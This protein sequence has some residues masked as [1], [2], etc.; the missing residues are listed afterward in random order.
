MQFTILSLGNVEFLSMVLNGV[1]MICGT[2]NFTQLVAVGFVLG[3]LFIG[4]QCIFRGGQQINLHHSF[5]CFLCYLCMFG[6]SCTVV[7]EDAYNGQA[8]TV[9]N[10]PLGVGAAGAAI[11]GIGYGVTRLIEQGYGAADRTSEQLGGVTAEALYREPWGDA[12]Q[13]PSEAH[14]VLLPIGTVGT[15]ETVTCAKGYDK[16]NSMFAKL[17]STAVKTAVNRMLKI[18]S[19]DGTTIATDYAEVTNAMDAVN[20]TMNGAQDLMQMIVLE[21]V[22]AEAAQKFY[23]TQ[24]D[25]A[26]A[27]AVNQAIMQRNTQWAAESTMFI[28]VARALMA[29]F[30]G[31]IYAITP[32]VAFLMAIGTFGVMLVGKYFLTIA[33]IQ[34]WLPI[35]SIVNLYTL[36]ACRQAITSA[37]LG[38]SAS[39]YALDVIWQDTQTWI[40]T[41]GMLLASTPM[42]A[43]FLVTG[44]T[45]A[46]TT[47]A[48][49]M[50]GQDHFNERIQTPDAV[51]PS[52]VM[53][54]ASTFSSD[55]TAGVRRTGAD[56]VMPTDNIGQT[57]SAATRSAWGTVN[58][59][60]QATTAAV[61]EALGNSQSA[62]QTNQFMRQVGDSMAASNNQ[63]FSTAIRKATQTAQK[64]GYSADQTHAAVAELGAA[65]QGRVTASLG[66]AESD[67][68][69]EAW[70]K[71]LSNPAKMI[72][73]ALGLE[74]KGSVSGS[75]SSGF[76]DQTGY[77]SQHSED[78]SRSLAADKS[79][80]MASS[81]ASEYS[82]AVSNMSSDQYAKLANENKGSSLGMQFAKMADARKAYETSESVA[83]SFG[84]QWSINRLPLSQMLENSASGRALAEFH[85][86]PDLPAGARSQ[87]VADANYFAPMMGG[88]MRQAQIAAAV[89]YMIQHPEHHAELGQK[90]L[91]S[92]LPMFRN[93][94]GVNA[95]A[96]SGLEKPAEMSA[97][98]RGFA[99]ARA[100]QQETIQAGN[101]GEVNM[102]AAR[103]TMQTRKDNADIKVAGQSGV[104]DVDA[105]RKG[106]DKALADLIN[107]SEAGIGTMLATNLMRDGFIGST[108]KMIQN[109]APNKLPAVGDKNLRD[110]LHD[111]HRTISGLTGAQ[112]RYMETYHNYKF[113]GGAS[114]P[115]VE[116]AAEGV[117]Q[118]MRG[119]LFGNKKELNDHETQTLNVATLA[120]L[121]HIQEVHSVDNQGLANQITNFNTAHNLKTDQNIYAQ[122]R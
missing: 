89:G 116:A 10:L 61:T 7:V 108:M 53:N 73:N 30:E 49:R 111:H 16:I 95:E 78:M 24:Q 115:K 42:L 14:T 90:L 36:T 56:N 3:L 112:E 2:G 87:M 114:A 93:I 86:K 57:F 121:N 40:S 58:A 12:W 27:I 101:P 29:F 8:R 28:S 66:N 64:A 18:K 117:R 20:A 19:V 91:D 92:G 1:A 25:Q 71:K 65:L 109:Y 103:E 74:V 99:T 48:G 85:R 63:Q 88:N 31:F 113:L 105:S 46:F 55:P 59:Q 118:E 41:G 72:A 94:G 68:A 15:E 102:E 17:S 51:A 107:G 5:L 62:S 43:L 35:M 44:S 38:T 69:D 96:N 50:S 9:A 122:I 119:A 82:T 23:I 32:I 83:R 22:Y 80:Q 54:H 81:L 84:S 79:R 120:M 110:Y 45:Y 98:E 100:K 39:F 76:K 34:L 104:N 13:L 97:F 67:G 11:S 33:W 60:A 70:Y 6:P 75:A 52:A 26:S 77:G 47:L 21:G 37:S 106:R 4:F